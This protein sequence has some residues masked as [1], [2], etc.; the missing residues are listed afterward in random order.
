M[1]KF[2]KKRKNQKLYKE[3]NIE[4][5]HIYIAPDVIIDG[6]KN[7]VFGNDIHVQPRM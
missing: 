7:V 4:K 6:A 5:K 1:K 3:L 2:F